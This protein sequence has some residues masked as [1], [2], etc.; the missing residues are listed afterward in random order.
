M[1]AVQPEPWLWALITNNNKYLVFKPS[2]MSACYGG[3]QCFVPT[4]NNRYISKLLGYYDISMLN[5]RERFEEETPFSS[6]T[7]SPRKPFW[8]VTLNIRTSCS[9]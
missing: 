3:G 5:I 8:D 4:E 1:A 6:R 7:K 2:T 9:F